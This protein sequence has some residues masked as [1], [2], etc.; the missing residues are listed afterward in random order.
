M[1]GM[2]IPSLVLALALSWAGSSL[3]GAQ[4]FS[5]VEIRT[6][7][8]A[9]GLHM[10]VGQGGNIGVVSGP[11]GVFLV[12]DQYAPLTEKI[13]AA[14]KE[15]DSGPVRFLVN[16]HWHGD[17]TGGNENLG[18]G[19]TV[20]VA[21]ENVRR[22]MSTEQV[23]RA[24]NR[25]V[26]PSPPAAL[27]VITFPDALTFHLNG[28]TIE[29]Q[30]HAAA[31]TDGDAVLWFT[32][33]NAVHMGDTY[34]NGMYPFI[35]TGSG[36]TVAGM[37]ATADAVLDRANDAT[38]IIPGHGPLSNKAELAAYRDLLGTV[39]D[40]VAAALASG[41]SPEQVVAAKPTA[42]LDATWATGFLKPE[43]FV[44]I[45]AADLAR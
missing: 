31:H 13:L 11:D 43:Q 36:G 3:A 40:R 16:T 5:K 9:D 15:I 22:R 19:G 26:P 4:D 21:H 24:F 37:L 34:F 23:M 39:R 28:V 35:D 8:V 32:G 18:K 10:L 1:G 44:G 29:V 42:D 45:V 30:H 2:R 17:H 25:T 6:V 33:K 38:K 14:V 12:D 7:A 27:P 41:Q 20:I